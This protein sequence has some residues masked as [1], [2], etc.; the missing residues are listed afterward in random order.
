MFNSLQIQQLDANIQYYAMSLYERAGGRVQFI[1]DGS[2]I[3]LSDPEL[4][5]KCYKRAINKYTKQ[6]K[7]GN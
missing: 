1:F 5:N 4:H 6:I 2:T 3:S 7:Q